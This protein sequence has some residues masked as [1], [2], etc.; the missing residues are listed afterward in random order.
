MWQ[1]WSHNW[2]QKDWGSLSA[3]TRSLW[4]TTWKYLGLKWNQTWH[5]ADS[6]QIC[7]A[8]NTIIRMRNLD[9]LPT[10]C[11]K[12]EPLPYKLSQKTSKDQVARQDFRLRSPEKGR[13]AE[14]TYSSEIGT[15][16]MNRP[17]YQNTWWTFAKEI[18]LWRTTSWQNTPMVVRR[19]NTRTPS[20]PLLV[21]HR[22]NNR[23]SRVGV[24]LGM[25]IFLTL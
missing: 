2:H 15:F 5:K 12:T 1:L 18:P 13:G 3:S 10:A 14:C 23:G 22:N 4:P 21:E 8:A 25:Y 19:S 7:G 16:K 20:K 6:L 24:P 9:S 11:Q 17:C